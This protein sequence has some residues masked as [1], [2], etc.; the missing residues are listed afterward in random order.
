MNIE[1][2]T[3]KAFDAKKKVENYS[4]IL[5]ETK[6]K[7]QSYFDKESAAGINSISS[8]GAIASKRERVDITYFPE[9]LREKLS[10]KMFARVTKREYVITDID[11]LVELMKEAGIKPNEF[12]S[13][14]NV[15]IDVDK[16]SL[17]KE[18]DIGNITKEDLDG[19]YEAK[20]VK[21]VDIRASKEG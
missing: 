20:I 21:W 17:K 18:F 14:L 7:L 6:A 13:L 11:G 15:K 10:K 5:A 3:K 9:K 1:G 16:E 2:L 4:A 8:E 19:C 12:K